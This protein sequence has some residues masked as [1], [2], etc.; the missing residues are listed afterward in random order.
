MENINL[1]FLALLLIFVTFFSFDLS[2]T[3]SGDMQFKEVTNNTNT[4]PFYGAGNHKSLK[5]SSGNNLNMLTLNP[6]KT[7]AIIDEVKN[8]KGA[9]S[10]YDFKSA[11]SRKTFIENW[12]P[13]PL[14]SNWYNVGGGT[15]GV[16]D[17]GAGSWLWGDN[18]SDT[19][20][21]RQVC[22]E[23]AGDD[24]TH[25]VRLRIFGA[26][27]SVRPRFGIFTSVFD[28]YEK[29]SFTAGIDIT[30][31][32]VYVTARKN[33]SVIAT[34]QSA[35]FPTVDLNQWHD[36]S[37]KKAG[38]HFTVFFDG[39]ALITLN[40]DLDGGRFGVFTEGSHAD[41]WT[42]KFTDT[43]EIPCKKKMLF[44]R[45][46]SRGPGE[47]GLT[48]YADS[49][50]PAWRTLHAA[51]SDLM[52]HTDPHDGIEK[53]Y[54]YFRG[55]TLDSP[56][57]GLH[58]GLWTQPVSTFD[59]EGSWEITENGGPWTD[60]GIVI[61]KS[62]W[63]DINGLLGPAVVVATNGD[64]YVYYTGKDKDWRA[65]FC[66]TKSTDGGYSFTKFST[67][68]LIEDVG[69]SSAVYHEGKYYIYFTDCKC[70][71]DKMRIHVVVT[72]NPESFT[73]AEI[74]HCLS[75]NA[76]GWDSLNINGG[77]VF[78]LGGKWWM[79]YEGGNLSF[80]YPF[81]FHAAYSDDLT[82]WIKVVNCKPLFLRGETASWDQGAIWWGDTFLWND[83]LYLLYEGWG[84]VGFT[85]FRDTN[86]YSEG[87]SQ[88][89]LAIAT[90]NDFLDWSELNN[91]H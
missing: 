89:G 69:P 75:P 86:Y 2:A 63:Y 22:Y 76:V 33:G 43:G 87:H 15:W 31:K 8:S 53:I 24:Y 28:S 26:Q 45:Y 82:N 3:N 83:K 38:R 40:A 19:T 10:M 29:N 66:G 56:Y 72:S 74:F 55:T 62:E 42:N 44:Q 48:I 71:Y 51:N 5:N 14:G 90:T 88:L 59:P 13:N 27:G 39:A 57:N 17:S 54:L 60:H 34:A 79:V 70:G 78:R 50:V 37:V 65:H 41:F 30:G 67:N 11:D 80:D 12:S 84:S 16:Y 91:P 7:N 25:S 32:F 20:F 61:S 6:V 4:S 18:T 46:G 73:N 9:L 58:I 49:S 35:S 64:I 52:R 21:R 47:E 36:L 77:R 1:L 23:R 68:P 81:R 85:P